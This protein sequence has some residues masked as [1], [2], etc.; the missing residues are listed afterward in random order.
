MGFAGA[1]RR[2]ELVTL[3]AADLTEAPDGLRVR[4]R[5]S[6]TDQEGEGSEIAIPRG[7]RLRAPVEA[8]QAW[9]AAAEIT[10]PQ[11]GVTRGATSALW[12][13]LADF[14]AFERCWSRA[15][16]RIANMTRLIAAAVFLVAASATA[17][18]CELN[19][20]SATDTQSTVASHSGKPAHGRS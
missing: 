7:Y 16:R 3:E 12:L 8:V 19:K 5:R 15:S 18:A 20:S 11:A 1:F 4:I 10:S 2:S 14:F 6:K 17:F 13:R 9:L